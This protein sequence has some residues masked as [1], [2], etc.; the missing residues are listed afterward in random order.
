MK[1]KQASHLLQLAAVSTSVLIFLN[2]CALK[3]FGN[4]KTVSEDAVSENI[5]ISLLNS[6]SEVASQIDKL[7]A[8]Y[9]SESGVN[10]EVRTVPSGVDS[11]ALLKG[12]YLADNIPD[13]IVC[14]SSGFANW[15]GLLEDMSSEEWVK[16]TDSAYKSSEYGVIGFPYTTEAIGLSYNADILEKAGVDPAAIT[17]PESFEAALKKIDEQ[18]S[19]LGLTAA[20]GYSTNLESLYWSSGNHLFGN[21]IDAGLERTDT[22]YI[23][24]LNDSKSLDEQRFKKFIDYIYIMQHYCDQK[25]LLDGTYEEQVKNFASGK[26]AFVTQGSW[27]GALLI[28]EHAEEYKAAGN[29]KVGMIPYT[30]DEG[31][32]TIL[33][34]PPSWWAVP[35]EGNTEAAKAFLQWCAGDSAQKILVED[36]GFIS[37]FKSCKY[38]ASDPFAQTV[39]SY[40]AS[41]KTSSWHWMDME[42]GMGQNVI[43]PGLYD[44]ARGAIDSTGLYYVLNDNIEKY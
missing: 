13:I 12:L 42:E 44:F 26:Y 5:S 35:K 29:F 14:E 6:K 10:V 1:R 21:Y 27:I 43:A 31:I 15:D 9:Q 8:A 39:S 4:A 40:L 2:G 41:G 11:Q 3:P 23:D 22:T 33:T 7:A 19:S 18:K 17:G 25:L 24:M 30:F 38:V 28:G 36:A 16:D 20:V 37:P 34:S 32:D